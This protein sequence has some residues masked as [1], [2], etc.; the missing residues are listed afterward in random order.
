MKIYC[1][2]RCRVE[3]K[4]SSFKTSIWLRHGFV[5]ISKRKI[6]CRDTYCYRCA[7]IVAEHD[8]MAYFKIGYNLRFKNIYAAKK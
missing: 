5:S 7:L 8:I 3:L 2:T 1:C 6:T 4:D